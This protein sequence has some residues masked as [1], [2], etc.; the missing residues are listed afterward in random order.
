M[1]LR[2]ARKNNLLSERQL[3]AFSILLYAFS[4][5]VA[6]TPRA[7]TTEANQKA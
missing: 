3:S 1:L 6:P 2:N 5:F 7:H 4:T